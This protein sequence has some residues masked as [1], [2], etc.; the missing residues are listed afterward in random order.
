VHVLSTER[1]SL[2]QLTMDDAPFILELTND[3]HWLLHIGDRGIR[4]LDDARRY[5]ENG[6]MEM[7][8]RLGFGLWAVEPRG[9]GA[10]LGIC[11]LLRRDWLDGVDVGFAFLP[12]HRGV[13]YAREA[14]AATLQHARDAFG[15]D[16]VLAIV[17]PANAASIRLLER[18]GMALERTARP[19]GDGGE[20]CVYGRTLTGLSPSPEPAGP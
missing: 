2:R 7:Y 10:P 20:V 8:G 6:P 17:S 1:L 9:G 3:P 5:V 11:G 13:G 15:I 16:R 18:L 19:P 4:T 14:A 12:A